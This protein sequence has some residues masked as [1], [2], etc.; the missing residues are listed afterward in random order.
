M[1]WRCVV[2]IP[3]RQIRMIEDLE[4]EALSLIGDNTE[5]IGSRT[6][7]I[8]D[9]AVGFMWWGGS[10]LDYPL[11]EAAVHVLAICKALRNNTCLEPWDLF[12]AA[13]ALSM[14]KYAMK[15]PEL[16]DKLKA[17]G[18]K[19]TAQK[20]ANVRHSQKGGSQEKRQLMQDVWAT[21]NY[22]SRDACAGAMH[23][24]LCISHTTP[25]KHL[26]NTPDP[27]KESPT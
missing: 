23:T 20:A 8:R 17:V 15:Y 25:R 1:A 5:I 4:K 3:E 7:S 26:R 12:A 6:A 27:T 19:E 9:G 18:R 24:K 11:P 13:E 10:E 21:D 2:D 16:A 14:W 22:A